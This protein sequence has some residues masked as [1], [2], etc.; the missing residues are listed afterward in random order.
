MNK[1]LISILN[2]ISWGVLLG[3]I[4]GV[5]IALVMNFSEQPMTTSIDALLFIF[6]YVAKST[7]IGIGLS[8][9]IW[10]VK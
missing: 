9:L 8:L 3:F 2:H 1:S 6:T 5:N 7:L 10:T 4:T